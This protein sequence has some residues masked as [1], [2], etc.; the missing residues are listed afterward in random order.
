MSA[1]DALPDEAVERLAAAYRR[2]SGQPIFP[3]ALDEIA[4]VVAALVREGAAA[5]QIAVL[6][7]AAAEQ[8]AEA[9]QVPWDEKSTHAGGHRCA[10]DFLDR[11]ADLLD[12]AQ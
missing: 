9:E 3:P 8:R 6:R 1:P 2:G 7:A 4:P 12:G 10:A 5:A 11:R